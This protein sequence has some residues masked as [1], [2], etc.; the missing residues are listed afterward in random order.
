MFNGSEESYRSNVYGKTITFKRLIHAS[1]SSTVSI[2][3][4]NRKV[5]YDG[6]ELFCGMCYFFPVKHQELNLLNSSE[7]ARE[8]RGKI[9]NH[10]LIEL[11]NPTSILQQEEAKKFFEGKS[12]HELYD[13]F[14]RA[15]GIKAAKD[16]YKKAIDDLNLGKVNS[17]AH[18]RDIEEKEV[19]L[20]ELE[21]K[22]RKASL[23]ND[24]G[25]VLYQIQEQ[26]CTSGKTEPAVMK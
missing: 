8:E 13:F 19:Q 3:A 11:D 4:D 24:K 25:Q 5:V 9:L 20:R 1:G 6:R 10:F 18:R 17:D 15:T 21:E 7:E 14:R 2:L 16:Q 22:F 23:A 12:D 26:K